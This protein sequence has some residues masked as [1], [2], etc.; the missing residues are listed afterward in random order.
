MLYL[1]FLNFLRSRLALA[2]LSFILMAGLISIHVGQQFLAKE[3][4]HIKN[5]AA[6]QREHI[7]RNVG[8]NKGE[9]GQVLYYLRFSLVNPSSPITALSIGQRD[10]NPSVQSVTI[11]NLE[12]Q[13]YDTDLANPANLLAGNLD[14]S[15]VLIYLFPLLIIVF[16]YNMLSEE[17]ESQTWRL[18]RVQARNPLTMLGHKV[19]VRMGAVYLALVILLGYAAVVLSLPM[20]EAFVAFVV[21]ALLYLA[22]WFA[23]SYWVMSWQGSSSTNAVS[24]ISFWVLLTIVC[25]ALVNNYLIERYPVPEALSTAV[26]NR[27]GY[28]EKWDMDKKVTM[29]AFYTHYPQFRKYGVPE[30]QFDYLWYYAMQQMGDDDAREHA[31]ELWEKLEIRERFNRSIA[32]FIPT[33]HTQLTANQLAKSGMLNH[34]KFL[35]GTTRFHEK[36][37]LH[38]YPKIFEKKPAATENWDQWEVESYVE[39]S[40]LDWVSLITPLLGFYLLFIFLGYNTL[41]NALS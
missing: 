24:L 26:E 38:F 1:A 8:Y 11:R 31:D 27:E 30:K 7:E 25:P 22:F 23:L 41:R 5:T 10:V 14:F 2:G 18:V 6:F 40:E 37:R 36:L 16:T 35:E 3:A 28:H 4:T 21:L 15:F 19:L 12:G 17:K 32:L 39:Q 9:I 20:D 29:D 34:L 33:I 13:K